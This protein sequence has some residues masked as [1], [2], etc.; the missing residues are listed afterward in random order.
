MSKI[1]LPET[2]EQLVAECQITTYRASGA[3][4]QHVNVTDSAVRLKHLPS[5]ITVTCQ[6][7]RSQYLNKRICLIKLREKVERLNYKAPPRIPTRVPKSAKLNN[8][9]AKTKHAQKK[10]LRQIS[11]SEE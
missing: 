8:R 2:D 10:R 5:G 4:G 9:L 7:E 3:G 6:K 1:I 11:S